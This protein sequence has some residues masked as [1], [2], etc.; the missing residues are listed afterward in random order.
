MSW[1]STLTCVVIPLIIILFIRRTLLQHRAAAMLR[2]Q[3]PDEPWLWRADWSARSAV[4]LSSSYSPLFWMFALVWTLI[5]LP[6][7]FIAD[8][9]HGTAEFIVFASFPIVGAILL[10]V[11]IYQTLRRRKYGLSVCRFNELPIALG[12]TLQAEVETRVKEIPQDGFQLRLTC[13][14]REVRRSGKSTSVN[15]R[16]LWQD[17]QRVG[18][19][20]AMPTPNGVRVPFRFPLPLEAEPADES[21]QRNRI[22]WRLE[23]IAEVPGIDYRGVFELPVFARAETQQSERFKTAFETPWTPHPTISLGGGDE[24]GERIVIRPSASAFDWVF[25]LVFCAIWFG[26]LALIRSLGGPLFIVVLFG[27]FGAVVL[28]FV[29]DRLA[30]RSVVSVNRTQIVARRTFLPTRI[31]PAVEIETIHPTIANANDRRALYDL[32]A[33]L[34]DGREVTIAK[35]LYTRR[36]AEMVAARILRAMG[37]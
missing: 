9:R 37:R 25:Y 23:V 1:I 33:R 27:L 35:Y 16:I 6:V 7:F 18:A 15:E 10:C 34:R 12:H 31:V 36:D 30:G 3:H 24:G 20:P 19:G 28:F 22:V 2:T 26:A 11:A 4:D 13:L 8:R 32:A 17:E 5:S 14:R 29:L 21:D